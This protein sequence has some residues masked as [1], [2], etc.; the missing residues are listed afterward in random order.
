[1]VLRKV[2][3]KEEERN[4]CARLLERKEN[5]VVRKLQDGRVGRP[6]AA[7]QAPR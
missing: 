7:F 3:K 6:C 4:T 2:R 1:M 5:G